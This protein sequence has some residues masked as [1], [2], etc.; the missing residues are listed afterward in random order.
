MMS[1]RRVATRKSCTASMEKSIWQSLKQSWYFRLR[2]SN[3]L[4]RSD[5]AR[6]KLGVEGSWVGDIFARGGMGQGRI[7]PIK[8]IIR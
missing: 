6:E 4:S 7:N 3:I 1:K 5:A 2:I 8:R